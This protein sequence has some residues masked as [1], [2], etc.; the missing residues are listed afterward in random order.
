MK[1]N[2]RIQ[3]ASSLWNLVK[4]LMTLLAAALLA[5]SAVSAEEKIAPEV[6]VPE[7]RKI[8]DSVGYAPAVRV[9]DMLYLSG[10]SGKPVAPD[11]DEKALRA[12]VISMFEQARA[13]LA[14]AGADFDNVVMMRTYRLDSLFLKA[15]PVF[16]EIKKRY[17]REP[18]PAWTDVGVSALVPGAVF[19]L[20]L[21]AWL[22]GKR[23]EAR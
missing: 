7:N 14:K 19:E 21:Q 13:V 10:V 3:R 15:F 12:N 2:S 18:Y 17:I 5:P 22:G 11:A 9:G 1:G 20:E 4:F 6:F 8:Y 23:K 16:N